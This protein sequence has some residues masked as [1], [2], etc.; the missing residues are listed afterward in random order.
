MSASWDLEEALRQAAIRD[1]SPM[2]RGAV[3]KLDP[4]L[5]GGG[6]AQGWNEGYEAG[7][8]DGVNAG[9]E[10]SIGIVEQWLRGGSRP[11]Y[12]TPS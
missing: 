11:T 3:K 5:I 10:R 4:Y 6:W 1:V 2:T 8:E 7:F 12:R 9:F